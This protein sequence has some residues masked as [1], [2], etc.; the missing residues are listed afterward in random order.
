M[1]DII[2]YIRS[3]PQNWLDTFRSLDMSK[4]HH[5]Q[6]L[7]FDIPHETKFTKVTQGSVYRGMC[8]TEDSLHTIQERGFL[9]SGMLQYCWARA[10]GIKDPNVFP[11][12]PD[13]QLEDVLKGLESRQNLVNHNTFGK[14][15]STGNSR[16]PHFFQSSTRIDNLKTPLFY[17]N[18]RCYDMEQT[19]SVK[20]YIVKIQLNDDNVAYTNGYE[21]DH[22]LKPAIPVKYLQFFEI[23]KREK[24]EDFLAYN[25]KMVSIVSKEEQEEEQAATR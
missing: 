20:R 21:G 24:D 22:I 5:G 3:H 6:F 17:A 4:V 15:L 1:G 12:V 11:D 13:D 16:S 10:H 19:H 2:T 23:Q 14:H 9:I 7:G 25:K 18:I 8:L